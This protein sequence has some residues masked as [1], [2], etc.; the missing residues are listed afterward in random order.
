MQRSMMLLVILVLLTGC[1][2]EI[3]A[4]QPL[5]VML[6]N[7]DG[8]DSP[9]LAALAEALTADPGYRVTVVAP[10][11]QQS[12]AGHALVIRREIAIRPHPAVGGATAVSVDA[13]PASVTAI[14]L[15]V[16]LEQDPPDLVVSGINKGENVGRAAWYSGTVGA[17]R[18][19]VLRGVPA[20]AL[21]L[22]LDWDDPKPD[23]TGAARLAKPVVDAVRSRGLPDGIVLNVNVPR[24]T[25]AARGY[26]ITSMGMTPDEVSRY[27]IDRVEDGVRYVTSR[28]APPDGAAEGSDVTA[29]DAGFV[30]LTP[31]T[32]DQTAYTALAPLAQLELTI[33]PAAP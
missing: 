19:A 12:A 11:D 5:H 26:R 29:L 7:D 4:D 23:W 25:A 30:P 24:D 18:E 27:A 3:E 6:V 14:G 21:S 17:A 15:T 31:L 22:E 2:A 10:H 28:W 9:G 33:P 16:V 8:V 32:L 13:T 1:A 20:I